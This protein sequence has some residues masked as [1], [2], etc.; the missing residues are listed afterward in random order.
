PLVAALV[1]IECAL[2]VDNALILGALAKTLP[3]QEQKRSLWIGSLSALIFRGLIIVFASFFIASPIVQVIGALYLA[4][5]AVKGLFFAQSKLPKAGRASFWKT[6]V[7]IELTDLIFAI[8]SIL[9]AIA[10][11]GARS[12]KLWMVYL[13]GAI[14]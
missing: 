12:D 14:G 3:V 9:A 13:G 4:Y 7:K 6:V 10:F 11:T 5:L 8:D 1:F 2:S